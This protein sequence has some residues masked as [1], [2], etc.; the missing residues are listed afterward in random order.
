M[1]PLTRRL[2]W[3]AAV[4]AAMT[5]ALVA[6]AA[7]VFVTVIG[8]PPSVGGLVGLVAGSAVLGACVAI[9]LVTRV[10]RVRRALGLGPGAAR[11]P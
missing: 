9:V 5:G 11:L 10:D 6:L 1:D 8:H 4:A 7:A 2:T 3:T